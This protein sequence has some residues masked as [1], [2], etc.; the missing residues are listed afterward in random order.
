MIFPT[1]TMEFEIF[2]F[3]LKIIHKLVIKSY[4]CIKLI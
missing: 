4:F 3:L 2:F 1:T